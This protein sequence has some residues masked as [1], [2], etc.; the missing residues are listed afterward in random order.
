MSSNVFSYSPRVIGLPCMIFSNSSVYLVTLLRLAFV[1]LYNE[2]V[3]LPYLPTSADKKVVS[4]P[5]SEN[6]FK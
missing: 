6:F 2:K 3:V 4:I 1:E 5:F